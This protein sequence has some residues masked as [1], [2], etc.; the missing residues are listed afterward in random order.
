[1][2]QCWHP[3]PKGRPKFTDLHKLFDYFL[4]RHTQEQY[5]YIDMDSM[6]PYTYDH[7]TH[8]AIS[9]YPTNEEVLD[10]DDEEVKGIYAGEGESSDYGSA[11][12]LRLF[13][14]SDENLTE[15][16]DRNTVECLNESLKTDSNSAYD[17]LRTIEHPYLTRI[18][19]SAASDIVFDYNRFIDDEEDEYYSQENEHS[20]HSYDFYDHSL[21]MK[22]LSTITE[23]S[24]EDYGDQTEGTT[25]TKAT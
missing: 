15:V 12:D 14:P 16:V 1:M 8:K 18:S 5:P 17:K 11:K 7:L 9:S 19:N 6:E 21:W 10:L 22:K 4:S 13:S 2:H 20:L 3:E 25:I 24:Y 23:V